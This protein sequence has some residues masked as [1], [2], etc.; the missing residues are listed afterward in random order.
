MVFTNFAGDVSNAIVL[1][2]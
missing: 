2:V 1:K